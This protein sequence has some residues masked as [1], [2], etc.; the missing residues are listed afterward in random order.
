M[1]N[2]IQGN[3]PVYEKELKKLSIKITVDKDN[4]LLNI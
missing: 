2:T 3:T 4:K 1:K